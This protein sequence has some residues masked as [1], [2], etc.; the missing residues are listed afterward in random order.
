MTSAET[1]SLTRCAYCGKEFD[2]RKFQ[3]VV[4]GLAYDSTECA[5]EAA[6]SAR[7]PREPEQRMRTGVETHV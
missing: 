2:G 3:V 4:A 5:H 1:T 7:A 6:D